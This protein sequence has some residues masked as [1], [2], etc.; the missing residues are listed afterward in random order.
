MTELGRSVLVV[1]DD[2]LLRVHV[3]TEDPGAALSFGTAT[4]TLL[5]VKVDNMEEQ[6]HAW[7]AE[8]ESAAT[9][10]PTHAAH[11][12]DQVVVAVAAGE[13]MAN[14][15]RGLG[16]AAIIQGGQTNNPSAQEI[17][18]AIE[19]GGGGTT[20]VLPNNK[21]IVLAAQQAARLLERDVRVIPAKTFP[22][23]V[24]AMIAFSP[25]ATAS[26]NEPAMTEAVG[27]VRSVE[28]TRAVRNATVK[29]VTV[30]EGS[31]IA[32]ID[33]DLALSAESA[34]EAAMFALDRLVTP[35]T[36]VV[37]V[38]WGAGSSDGLAHDLADRIRGA[39]AEFEVEVVEGGQPL[40]PYVLAVE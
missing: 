7:V 25:E 39:Y 30:A 17:L 29:G 15:L 18:A 2:S 27:T 35:D 1:G 3:H 37:T 4:G 33:G 23:G 21:N 38:Y 14:V 16:V 13:G 31:F 9:A 20:F 34:E 22:Q 24:S 5:K 28:V 12:A 26:E 8:H 19:G 11:A 40:Y 32:I 10:P 6:Y 36:V